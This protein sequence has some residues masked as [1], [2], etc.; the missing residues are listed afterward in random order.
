MVTIRPLGITH[1]L[2]I[3][4]LYAAVH[5]VILPALRGKAICVSLDASEALPLIVASLAP[6]SQAVWPGMRAE[7]AKRLCPDLTGI[8]QEPDRYA[9]TIQDRAKST[10]C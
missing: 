2:R 7:H 9:W 10:G 3:P 5:Q 6:R 1:H 4:A 8:V